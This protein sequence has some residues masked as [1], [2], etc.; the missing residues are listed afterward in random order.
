MKK[1]L[2]IPRVYV[3]PP[4]IH[5]CM[6]FSACLVLMASLSSCDNVSKGRYKF[7]S[8]SVHWSQFRG[9]NASGIATEDVNP[10]VHFAADTNVLWKTEMLPGWSSPCIVNDKIFL[11]GFND[12][13]SLLY[14]IAIDREK[15]EI[16]WRDSVAPQRYYSLHPVNGYA[17]PTAASNGKQIFTH[18]PGYGLIAYGLDGKRSWEFKHW[19]ITGRMGGA[20]SPVIVD[21]MVIININ[22]SKDPR[23]QA[24]DCETG[25]TLWAI[26]DP[27]HKWKSLGCSASPVISDD[28]IILHQTMEIVAY[29]ITDQQVQWWFHTPTTA[30]S[31]PVIRDNVLYTSTWVHLGEKNLQASGLDFESFLTKFDLNGNRRIDKGEAPDS[32]MIAQRPES[33]NAPS[34]SVTFNWLYS[35]FDENSDGALDEQEW[36]AFLEVVGPYL[37]NHGMLAIPVQG[38]NERLYTDLIWK[39][40]EDA[41]ETPS[42]LV[43][44]DYAFFIKSG[45]I[46]T[47]VNRETG[48]V[49]KKGRIGAT[50][51]Y[52]SSPMLAG[53]KIYTCAYNGT[54]T[55][56]SAD[57]F[58]ILA[59]N[60][61]KEKIGASPVAVDDVLYVRTDKH[62]YAFRDP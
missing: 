16:L 37:E 19:P 44:G 20:S 8:E 52:L 38:A 6:T 50:G 25:D 33:R 41:P 24:L 18:F 34:S 45:G 53:N 30:M 59:H 62:L 32:L 10:P 31:T 11:T 54:V 2:T 35:G 1:Y 36:N 40:N 42:P 39:I 9:P 57:D 55:V 51:T 17:N 56:L 27:D 14:T 22:S 61:L 47:V 4:F 13:D 3:L 29:N 60:K 12:S 5:Y 48:D 7:K 46:I 26:R 23:I 43:V 49:F 58:S 15:G 28:L 21:S